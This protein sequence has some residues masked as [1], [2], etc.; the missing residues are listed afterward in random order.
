MS[1]LNVEIVTPENL[2]FSDTVHMITMPGTSG[3]FGVLFGHVP[4]ISS[5]KPGAVIVHDQDMKI[6]ERFFVSDGFAEVKNTSVTLLVEKAVRLSDL[7]PEIFKD[8]IKNLK[9]SLK[10]TNKEQEIEIINKNICF[11]EAVLASLN[12]SL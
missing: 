7:E 6:V 3:E 5:I 11:A 2:L 12:N 10:N 4:I 1:A 8:E 9:E